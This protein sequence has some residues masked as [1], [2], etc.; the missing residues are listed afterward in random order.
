MRQVGLGDDVVDDL[1][2]HMLGLLL[3]LLHQ[4][5]TLNGLG[6][7]RIVFH[8]RGDGQL[9]ARLQAC[10]HDRIQRG[11][12]GIDGGGPASRTRTDDGD[13]DSAGCLGHG[14]YLGRDSVIRHGPKAILSGQCNAGDVGIASLTGAVA[15]D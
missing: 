3:H 10:D 8:V 1:C 9:A 4:P 13:A 11:A 2:A 12:G 7:A 15:V 5:R 6:K 14:G